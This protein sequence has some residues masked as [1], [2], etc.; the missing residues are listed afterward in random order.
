MSEQ[1]EEGVWCEACEEY[2]DDDE[3]CSHDHH[4][5]CRDCC[6]SVEPMDWNDLD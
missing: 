3:M 6:E 2:R 5:Y 4:T 1:E